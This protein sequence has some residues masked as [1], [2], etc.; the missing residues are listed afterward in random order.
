[1]ATPR[2]MSASRYCTMND[3]SVSPV[4]PQTI[5]NVVRIEPTAIANGIKARNDPNTKMRTI[6]AP[7]RRGIPT[8]HGVYISSTMS[9]W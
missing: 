1:M 8:V 7:T 3:T 4:R 5:K 2:P 9:E 6:S